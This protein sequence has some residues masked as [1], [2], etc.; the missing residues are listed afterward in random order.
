MRPFLPLILFI[1]G[2]VAILAEI[3][4]FQAVRAA[5]KSRWAPWAYLAISLL[6]IAYIVY[7]FMHFDRKEGQNKQSLLA[8]GLLLITFLPKIIITIVMLGEDIIRFF[9]GLIRMFLGDTKQPFLQ[10]RRRFVSLT[11]LALAAIPFFSLLYGMTKG[12]YNFK[13]RKQT[14]TYPDLPDNFD[15]MTITQI[16][17]VHSGSLDNV[18]KIEYAIDLIN[19]QK[20]DI[21]LFTGDIVNTH[22]TELHP[23]I[24]TFKRI[25][26]PPMGKFSVLGNHDYGEYVD[27]PSPKA[28]DDNFAAIKDLHRQIN[29]KL[30]LNENIKLKKGDQHIALI[31]VE[32]WGH[33]FKKA[34]D[35]IKASVGIDKEDFKIL[36]SHDPSHWEYEVQHHP[37]NYH[38]TLS[39]HTHGMQF[40]IEIPGFLKWSP[41]QYV[42]KQWAGLYN[43]AKRYVYVNRGFGFHGY[44]GRTG[45]W[46]EITVITL[47]KG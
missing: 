37:N 9:G 18:E 24:E 16:S 22:A 8:M 45:I 23:W 21:I 10:D 39:G 7:V 27:W 28:K 11:A 6:I 47:K 2:V 33:N 32:N 40:G 20:S 31:G 38:L 35:L 34:G 44:A 29:F 26:T 42:Y 14:I 41:V 30:M 19:E 1:T 46:P 25:E 5:T 4:T 17:D 15:G 36:M 3:Y 43:N 13:V 12:K